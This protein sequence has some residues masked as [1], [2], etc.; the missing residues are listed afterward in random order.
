VKFKENNQ[1]PR[2]LTNEL[3]ASGLAHLIELPTPQVALIQ[4]IPAFLE[5]KGN[6]FLR[7]RYGKPVSPGVH[8]GSQRLGGVE[9]TA[10][11]AH[12][13]KCINS[14]LLP[15]FFVFDM[16][17]NNSDRKMEHCLIVKPDFHPKGYYVSSVDHGHCFGGPNWTIAI[18]SQVGTWCGS[19]VPEMARLVT[20]DAPFAPWPA[21][22]RAVSENLID[23]VLAEIPDEW[24]PSKQERAALRMF[25]LAQ[26]DRVPAI[27]EANRHL[28]PNWKGVA[29]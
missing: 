19:H 8:F 12:L 1:G 4:I 27:L 29:L 6:E 7:T 2:V 25:V 21:K 5:A 18:T 26:R 15:G 14:D 11:A 28:F 13:S 20:G 16:W 23:A 17:T 10:V 22:L 3:V 9:N 24:E